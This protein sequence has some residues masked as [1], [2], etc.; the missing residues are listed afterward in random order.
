MEVDERVTGYHEALFVAVRG[1]S[2]LPGQAAY[3]GSTAEA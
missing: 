1:C 2:Q 3:S